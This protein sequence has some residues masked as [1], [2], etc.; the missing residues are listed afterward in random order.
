MKYINIIFTIVIIS[1]LLMISFGCGNSI[2]NTP[3]QAVKDYFQSLND[4]DCKKNLELRSSN[5]KYKKASSNYDEEFQAC[6]EW[7]D[8]YSPTNYVKINDVK[9][10][11]NQ[12]EVREVLTIGNSQPD[13]VIVS[14]VVEDNEWKIDKVQVDNTP[15]I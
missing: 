12:A 7:L 1:L 11:G 3:E 8:K 6:S 15:A 4:R 13:N 14:L 10:N 5:F 2:S 9:I